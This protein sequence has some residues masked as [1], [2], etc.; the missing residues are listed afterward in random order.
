[1]LIVHDQE[2]P[3]PRSNEF[4]CRFPALKHASSVVVFANI[5]KF[6]SLKGLA[7]LKGVYIFTSACI[8]IFQAIK[9]YLKEKKAR[10]QFY[11]MSPH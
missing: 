10:L 4:V 3:A 1:M 7:A 9:S 2:P 5:G 6:A 8:C 11:C